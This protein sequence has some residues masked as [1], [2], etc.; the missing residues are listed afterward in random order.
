MKVR[1]KGKVRV[2]TLGG[3]KGKEKKKKKRRGGEER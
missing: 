1:K 2:G 3:G